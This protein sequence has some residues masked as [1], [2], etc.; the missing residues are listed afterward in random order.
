MHKLSKKIMVRTSFRATHSWP[1][2]SQFAGD[3]VSFLEA[4]HRHTFHVKAELHV[5]DSDR[6]VEFFVFQSQVDQAIDK[7]YSETKDG[8]VFNLGRRSCETI[9]E[10][11]IDSLRADHSYKGTIAIEIWEDNEVGGQ[12][13]SYAEN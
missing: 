9:A 13:T 8:I 5:T 3:E 2:A 11:V 1:E 4:R 7:L 12:V 6:E 10:E